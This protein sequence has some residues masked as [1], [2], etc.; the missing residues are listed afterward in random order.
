MKNIVVISTY[1]ETGSK[2]IGDQLIT[3]SVLAAIKGIAQKKGFEINIKTVFRADSWSNVKKIICKAD[4]IVFACL[5]IR[6]KM[7]TDEYPYL[8]KILKIGIPF[9]VVSSGTSIPVYNKRSDILK[10]FSKDTISVLRRMDN[11]AKFFSTRGVLSQLVCKEMRIDN[12]FFAGDIA[13][14]SENIR[15]KAFKLPKHVENIVVSSPHNPDVYRESL[16]TLIVDLKKIFPNADLVLAQHGESDFFKDFCN[17][18]KIQLVEI[19]KDKHSGL[20]IY[21]NADLHVGYRV[22]AHV[23]TLKRKKPSY[24]LEQDGRGADYGLTINVKCSVP[25]Y[26]DNIDVAEK[27]SI[28]ANRVSK[29][30]L[31]TDVIERVASPMPAKLIVSMIENDLKIGFSKFNCIDEQVNW[32]SEN[33]IEYLSKIFE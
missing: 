6:N 9:G 4:F 7:T 15:N 33:H 31:S 21:D 8:E 11:Q 18:Q 25:N 12:S 5:A 14:F 17:K 27:I 19:Y 20:A 2:N 22:H 10:G 28:I 32:F 16:T 30:I 26:I 29:K 24:L 3:D 23:S 13:F 1:P